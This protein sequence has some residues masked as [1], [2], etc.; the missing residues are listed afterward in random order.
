MRAVLLVIDGLGVGA[1]DDCTGTRPVD[2]SANTLRH[3]AERVGGLHLLT[4]GQMGLGNILVVPGICA[5]AAPLA[6]FAECLLAY[7]GADSFLGHQEIMGTIP[8]VP[9]RTLMF[10][11]E[12][13]LA[14]ALRAG[15]HKVASPFPGLPILLVDDAVV[16]G[17]NLEAEPGQII[18]LT[19]PTSQ[20][21]FNHALEI[22]RIVRGLVEVSRVI[23]FGG[24]H[25]G[26]ADILENVEVRPSDQAGVNSPKLG[27]Y[28]SNLVVRHLGFGVDSARQLANVWVRAG[29]PVGLFGKMADLVD[30]PSAERNAA[31]VTGQV[32]DW[33][34][35]WL[36]TH[37]DGLVA[38]TVQETDLAGHE[39]DANRYAAVLGVV[40]QNLQIGRAHV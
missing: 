5:S 15:G 36:Q 37:S 19:V 3:V 7:Y 9:C 2:V 16:I 23:V 30:C 21:D 10:Q 35:R 31:V 34:T 27:V 13:R 17:D 28:D 26:V 38:A 6:S 25:I 12:S 14:I 11:A 22:G 29:K 39:N 33:I 8:R 40:D 18:N 1:M 32:M 4:L 24:P 20:I